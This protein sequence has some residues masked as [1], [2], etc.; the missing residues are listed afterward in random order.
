MFIKYKDTP[1][2]RQAKFLI[3]SHFLTAGLC[4]DFQA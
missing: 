3:N 2:P 1:C 4:Y